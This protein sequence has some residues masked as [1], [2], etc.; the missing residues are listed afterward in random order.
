VQVNPSDVRVAVVVAVR[1]GGALLAKCLDS[2]GRE[3]VGP[4]QVIVVDDASADNTDDVVQEYRRKFASIRS[5]RLDEP[6]GPYKARDVAVAKLGSEFTH[7]IFFDAR[8]RAR[9]GWLA[10]HKTLQAMPGVAIS[11]T[12]VRT[13][14]DSSLAGKIASGLQL[15][16]ADKFST[17]LRRHV[18]AA[19]LGVPIATYRAV[20]GFNFGR[21]GG[22]ADLCWRVQ[23]AGLG[24][25]EIDARDLATWEPRRSL[26]AAM[27][28]YFRYGRSYGRLAC[29]APSF[30]ARLL[31]FVMAPLRAVVGTMRVVAS[32][33]GHP[34]RALCAGIFYHVCYQAGFVRGLFGARV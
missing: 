6:V 23:D 16:S 12:S 17:I 31:G 25:V 26:R 8:V 34:L 2:L 21:A 7:V 27:E 28:Q 30:Q 22:D 14:D 20:G 5:V 10:A 15:F 13:E 11:Y 1:D 19:N 3:V 9:P 18:P 32:S 33:G 4:D 29:P 24:R